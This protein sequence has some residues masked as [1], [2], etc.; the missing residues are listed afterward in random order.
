MKK[1]ILLCILGISL[2]IYAAETDIYGVP[3]CKNNDSYNC[4]VKNGN[5]GPY[6]YQVMEQRWNKNDGG[7][8]L[9]NDVINI[10]TVTPYQNYGTL[11]FDYR[12]KTVQ[13]INEE[14]DKELKQR[15]EEQNEWDIQQKKKELKQ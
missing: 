13:Q 14:Y 11:C 3:Y 8:T 4:R 12:T 7:K 1:F 9:I 2:P 5:L 15:K 6:Q 10:S